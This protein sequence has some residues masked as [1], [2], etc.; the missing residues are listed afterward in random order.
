[1]K[2]Y[3]YACNDI[4]KEKIEI[5]A[6]YLKKKQK[7]HVGMTMKEKDK[8]RKYLYLKKNYMISWMRN[9]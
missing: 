1:M 6:H 4:M 9:I 7:L 2:V 5:N 8:V 3:E